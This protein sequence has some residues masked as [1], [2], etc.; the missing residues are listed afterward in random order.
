MRALEVINLCDKTCTR[1]RGKIV[2]AWEYDSPLEQQPSL[3]GGAKML[4]KPPQVDNDCIRFNGWKDEGHETFL[5]SR[6]SQP[7]GNESTFDFC[8]TE[9]KP[10]DLAVMLC[11][12]IMHEAAPG[13][14]RVESDGEW[15][16]EWVPARQAYEKLFGKEP[17][18]PFKKKSPSAR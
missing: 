1:V 4:P 3:F 12:I 14:F 7:R 16:G 8:K 9:R 18:S 17:K 11:L 2:L 6:E 13:S 10:Y 15:D 5:V